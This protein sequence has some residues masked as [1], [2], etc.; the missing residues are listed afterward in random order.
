MFDI[1][2]HFKRRLRWWK[3]AWGS[4][5]IYF[6]RFT[7]FLGIVLEV[8]TTVDLSPFI[9]DQRALAGYMIVNGILVELLRRRRWKPSDERFN[10]DHRPARQTE[11][12]H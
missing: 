6:A 4:W 10:D 9:T 12:P 1:R 3:N 7:I 8:V 5:S 2:E 11:L